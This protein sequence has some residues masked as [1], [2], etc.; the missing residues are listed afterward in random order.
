[1]MDSTAL[2]NPS[3][4]FEFNEKTYEEDDQEFQRVSLKKKSRLDEKSRFRSISPDSAL[5]QYDL[6]CVCSECENQEFPEKIPEYPLSL[7]SLLVKDVSEKSMRSRLPKSFRKDGVI[8]A[9]ASAQF[10]FDHL[11]NI[12]SELGLEDSPQ[13]LTVVD[14]RQESHGFVN[15]IPFSWYRCR[16][17]I[18]YGKSKSM[19]IISESQAIENLRYQLESGFLEQITLH[20]IRVKLLGSVYGS[21][22]SV[23]PKPVLIESEQ[24]ICARLGVNYIRFPV[25]DHHHPEELVVEAF[26]DFMSKII[27]SGE[28]KWFHFH[29]KGG[30]GR[31]TSFTTMLDILLYFKYNDLS[32]RAT[33]FAYS[34]PEDFV[35]RQNEIG[36]SNLFK[37]ARC[38]NKQWK[39]AAFKNRETFIRN[40]FAYCS[41]GSTEAWKEWL[42]TQKPEEF[43]QIPLPN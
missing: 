17:L 10:T 21:E 32:N 23:I 5:A 22:E 26:L 34:S 28:K 11:K 37:P 40:F 2:Y 3:S 16:N 7:D 33:K 4:S 6:E 29:C 42:K 20:E 12:I 31:S 24:E 30:R 39:F 9:S 15:G 41:L 38:K 43:N 13:T 14:L 35:V 25:V 8:N 19:S 36:G 27:E 18:N 1:M